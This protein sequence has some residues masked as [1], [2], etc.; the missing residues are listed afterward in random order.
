M[1]YVKVL[2]LSSA[3]ALISA[4]DPAYPLIVRNDLSVPVTARINISGSEGERRLQP[5]ETL[6]IVKAPSDIVERITLL[7]EGRVL[8]DLDKQKLEELQKS[9]ADPRNV[10]W[11]IQPSGLMP[12]RPS[13]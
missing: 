8:Y 13:K 12:V 5:G 3:L 6:Q 2:A 1:T 10:T 9:V 11:E 7:S 4:C